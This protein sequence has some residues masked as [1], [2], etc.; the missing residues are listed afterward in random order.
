[1]QNIILI[2]HS[3]WRWAVVAITVVA[4]IRFLLSWLGGGSD[5]RADRRFMA[6]FTGAID[7]QTLLGIVYLIWDGLARSGFPMYRI[8]HAVTMLIAAGVAHL[9]VR[10]RNAPARLRARNYFLIVVAVLVLIFAGIGRLPQGWF[11]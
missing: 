8:E 2:L 9:G 6:A 10:W 1:M 4:A 5:G 3:Y 11:G 7:L